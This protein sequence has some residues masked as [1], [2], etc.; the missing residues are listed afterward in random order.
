M[1]QVSTDP[2]VLIQTAPAR[3]AITLDDLPY[4]MPSRT[5][6]QEGLAYTNRINSA[7][8]AHGIVATGF[9]VGQQINPQSVPALEAFAKAGHTIGN[10][11]WSHPDYGSLTEANFSTKPAGPTRLWRSGSMA[12][13]T[14]A[15]LSCAKAKPRRRRL[16]RRRF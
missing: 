14:I 13:D 8:Q 7:L 2:A 11:S 1:E 3:I 9:A 10:H 16:L 6:P 5:D 15:F 4:V 12:R